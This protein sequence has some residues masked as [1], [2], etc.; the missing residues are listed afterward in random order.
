MAE[1]LNASVSKTVILISSVSWVRIPHSLHG[2][3]FLFFFMDDN[4]CYSSQVLD[5]FHHP[6]NMGEIKNA[7]CVGTVGNPRCGDIMRLY[8]LIDNTSKVITD[9]KFKT[10]GCTAAIATSSIA[11]ELI[12]GKTIFE[13]VTIT[14]KAVTEALHGL[15]KI[16]IH[17]SVLA[18]EAI[19]DALYDYSQKHNIVI[20][21]LKYKCQQ[22]CN[23]CPYHSP[24]NDTTEM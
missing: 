20:P 24:H 7:S 12:K 13:A 8:L 18:K 2:E 19:H 5:H 23:S 11:T 17:C 9:C 10:F 14:D 22:D 6:R 1:W 3:L 16:K 4:F 21:G 15:P